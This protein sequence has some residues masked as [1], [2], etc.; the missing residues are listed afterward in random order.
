MLSDKLTDPADLEILATHPSHQRKGAGSM[1]IKH[2]C[3]MADANDE[4]AYL[5]ASPEGV[6]T[7]RRC[8]FEEKD[9]VVVTIKGEEYVNLCMVREP[10]RAA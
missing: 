3:R 7:Y 6:S 1:L 4:V 5:E 8:G 10:M 2:V 9:Q